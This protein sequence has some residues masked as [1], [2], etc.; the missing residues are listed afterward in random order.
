[1][2]EF[3]I[4]LLIG[5]LSGIVIGLM[6]GIPAYIGPLILYPFL[7]YLSVDQILAFWLTSHIG[8]QYFGSVAAILLKIPGEVSSMIYIKDIGKLNTTERLGLVSQT[9]WGSTIGS[10]VSL[11]V[12]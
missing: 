6:P 12:I 8:S 1:M 4:I 2:L 5:L 9:A 3:L 7:A 11:M 10:M